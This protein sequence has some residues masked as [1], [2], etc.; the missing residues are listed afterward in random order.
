MK[1]VNDI[2]C[3][4]FCYRLTILLKPRHDFNQAH[5]CLVISNHISLSP[6]QALPQHVTINDPFY[7]SNY[8]LR[9]ISRELDLRKLLIK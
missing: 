5:L 4:K 2:S 7:K 1:E 8:L 3:F 9:Y 6:F